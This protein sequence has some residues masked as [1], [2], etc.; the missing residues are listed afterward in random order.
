MIDHT[1]LKVSYPGVSR[2][3]YDTAEPARERQRGVL[4][5]RPRLGGDRAARSWAMTCPRGAPVSCS[6]RSRALEMACCIWGARAMSSASEGPAAT[7]TMRQFSSR[8]LTSSSSTHQRSWLSSAGSPVRPSSA[9][10]GRASSAGIRRVK[11]RRFGRT[12]F[13]ETTWFEGARQPSLLLETPDELGFSCEGLVDHLEGDVPAEAGVPRAVDL[14]H[15]PGAEGRQHLVRTQPAAG[16]QTHVARLY[17]W[18]KRGKSG[19]GTERGQ[20]PFSPQKRRSP[21]ADRWIRA[22]FGAA[23]PRGCGAAGRARGRVGRG[24]EN[25]P[26]LPC[27]VAG[28]GRLIQRRNDCIR[29]YRE[30]VLPGARRGAAAGMRL[31]SATATCTGRTA[32]SP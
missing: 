2:R 23:D 1:G 13:P 9:S 7:A 16:S 21:G 30:R 12:S 8:R 25:A 28:C 27:V 3:F 31:T 11:E 29:H 20:V 15:S 4:R 19:P 26:R 32:A 5:H 24:Q 17:C 18:H 22:R 14:G 10:L 6:R